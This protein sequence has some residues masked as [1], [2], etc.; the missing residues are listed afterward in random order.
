MSHPIC[1]I[2]DSRK[3]EVFTAIFNLSD[4]HGMIRI[5][6]D[7][8]LKTGDLPSIIEGK[9]LFLGNDF[10]NQ[11]RA[12]MKMLG[13]KAILAPV[14]LWNLKASAVGVVGL[15]RFLDDD[16]DDL[17]DL[18]PSRSPMFLPTCI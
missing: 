8:C 15:E 18:V 11:G 14:H 4:D 17:Q 1:P 16:F 10:K 2:I 7:T 6:Q 9:T 12:I 3:G 13:H 5:K